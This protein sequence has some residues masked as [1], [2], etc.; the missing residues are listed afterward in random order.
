MRPTH[1]PARAIFDAF[2]A[3]AACRPG[4]SAAI[5]V[6]AE[7]VA[8]WE[9]AQKEAARLGLNAP[10]MD[11]VERAER[12]AC[13]HFDYGAKWAYGVVEAMRLGPNN[14]E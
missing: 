10:T 5:W 6:Q 4:R 1:H 7:R 9:A 12:G 8:V 11:E 3:E 13:G 2:H 14:N